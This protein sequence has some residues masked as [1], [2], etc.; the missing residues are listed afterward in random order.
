VVGDLALFMVANDLTPEDVKNPEKEISFPESVVSMMRG[1]LG[2]PAD[3]FPK[4]LQAKVLKG[5]KP[6]EGRV[7]AHLPAV[8]LEAER[9]KAEKAVGHQLGDTDLASYLMYPKVFADYADH[10]RKYGDVSVLPT[11]V[12]FY[13]LHERDE[14]AVD[15]D[16]GKTLVVRLT[17]QT[18][19]DDEGE[20][21]LFF[22]LNG[23]PR[24]MR[25]G[26]TGMEGAKKAH[27]KA[28][29]GNPNH[30]PAPMPGAVSTVAVKPGQKVSKGSPL[31]SIEAMKMETAITAD[32]DAT[33][34]KVL[35]H[36]GDRVEP[37]DLLV[38]LG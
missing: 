34:V 1:E 18:Q 28:Q 15:I 7:G 38:E 13:G 10:Q 31:V 19:V 12:F 20:V 21:K 26:K 35:V 25:I 36:P 23:Q 14:M 16:K 33:V 2:Y 3:G 30:V 22:E 24:P 6:I 4:E 17:G 32:R 37:K 27:P 9:A 8:D 29:D 11:P 5:Q